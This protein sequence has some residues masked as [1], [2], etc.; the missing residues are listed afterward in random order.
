[1]AAFFCEEQNDKSETVAEEQNIHLDPKGPRIL[2]IRNTIK[3][4]RSYGKMTGI[5]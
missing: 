4:R 2:S 5:S 3:N 1:M